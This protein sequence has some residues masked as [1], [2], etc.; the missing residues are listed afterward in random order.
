MS[1]PERGDRGPDDDEREVEELAE[2]L[3]SRLRRLPN[4]AEMT[5]YAINLLRESSEEA[6]QAEQAQAGAAWAARHDPFNPIAFAIP[7]A[8]VGLVLCATGLLIGPG[9]GIIAVA[10][11]MAVYGFAVS[12]VWRRGKREDGAKRG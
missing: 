7:L 4:R 12:L 3:A 9:L 5:D 11:L 10:V 8:V 2:K 6:Q 1:D